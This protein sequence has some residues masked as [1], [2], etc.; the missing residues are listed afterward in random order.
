[1]HNKLEKQTPTQW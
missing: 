1:M